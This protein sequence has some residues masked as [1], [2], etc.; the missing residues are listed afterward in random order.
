MQLQFSIS[1]LPLHVPPLVLV[2]LS[3]L[4]RLVKRGKFNKL[5]YP[6]LPPNRNEFD[7]ANT[8]SDNAYFLN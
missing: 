6:Y 5:S 3:R 7:I 8:F 4:L 2:S 1:L